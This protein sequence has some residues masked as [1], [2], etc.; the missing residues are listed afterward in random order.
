M[1]RSFRIT[2]RYREIFLLLFFIAGI[3][4]FPGKIYA[5]ESFHG[6]KYQ[7][8]ES[9]QSQVTVAVTI[10]SDGIPIRGFDEEETALSHVKVTVPY[11]DLKLYGME[12]FY[13]YP[14]SATC[15]Y[16]PER[17]V[18]KRP[19]LLHLYIY[20]LEKYYLG[21]PEAQC[22][23]GYGKNEIFNKGHS[24][25][26][27][28]MNGEEAY[29]TFEGSNNE[30]RKLLSVTGSATSLYMTNFWGHDENLNYY[31]NHEYPL[32][33][34]DWGASADYILLE[35]GDTVD[36]AMFTDYS[37][38]QRSGFTFFSQDDYQLQTGETLR[39]KTYDQKGSV[40]DSSGSFYTPEP[41]SMM[42]LDVKL[43]DENWNLIKNLEY[44]SEGYISCTFDKAG[45]WYLQGEEKSLA[46]QNGAAIA[47]ATARITVSDNGSTLSVKKLKLT[48]EGNK[49]QISVGEKLQLNVEI[50]PSTALFQS[51]RWQVKG[52][53][54]YVDYLGF[55]HG[56]AYIDK[57]QSVTV[58]AVSRADRSIQDSVQIFVKADR[59]TVAK[60]KNT[61][62]LIDAIGSSE[63]DITYTKECEQKIQAARKAYD[64]LG[65][66]SVAYQNV[67]EEKTKFL[68]TAELTY[69][70]LKENAEKVTPSPKPT[71]K[72]TPKP[73]RKPT[74]TPKPAA[75]P[76]VNNTKI[77][78]VKKVKSGVL[79]I[80]WKKASQ[81]S[82]Y[83]IQMSTNS[84]SGFKKI[85]SANS[86]TVVYRK[87]GLRKGRNYYFRIR[88]FRIYKG[89]KYYSSWSKTVRGRP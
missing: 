19:T 65:K 20:M 40:S 70:K 54:G 9:N 39:T 3:F 44:D 48:T 81:V 75:K 60:V 53:A 86:K 79:T 80:K 1:E 89:K 37:F 10:S 62:A 21:I 31:V 22:G 73:T 2:A 56:K 38:Y 35:D 18:I 30:E 66:G 85:R 59:E 16:E 15:D 49:N 8:N 12:R 32:I 43:Y 14:T 52:T 78:S 76:K 72:V 68:E 42:D 83:E 51:V 82:G 71:P 46:G 50:L 17:G 55:F 27:F 47:P 6:Q 36:L 26:I 63:R 67:K 23:K 64:G 61:E 58:T 41:S 45:N 4:F 28:Y 87:T 13:R 11:F 33:W 34:S 88:S 69:K 5:K 25:R 74:P 7:Y 84:K 29:F 77:T 24:D 57:D